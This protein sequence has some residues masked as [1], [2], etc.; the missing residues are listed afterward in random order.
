LLCDLGYVPV[1]NGSEKIHIP[2]DPPLELLLYIFSATYVGTEVDNIY[3]LQV[4][5]DYFSRSSRVIVL[6]LFSSL[7]L[8]NFNVLTNRDVKTIP[9]QL[10]THL[11]LA[12][13]VFIS[14]TV[15]VMFRLTY[16][17]VFVCHST[18]KKIIKSQSLGTGLDLTIRRDIKENGRHVGPTVNTILIKLCT[19]MFRT[20]FGPNYVGF[21]L[22]I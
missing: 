16:L 13:R 19:Q 11:I 7:S 5:S 1:R 20:V 15:K 4:V 22:T 17:L 9:T 12:N 6:L 3:V 10:L 14:V 8:L 21:P 2:L 18:L